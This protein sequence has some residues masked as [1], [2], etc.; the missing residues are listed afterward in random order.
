[1]LLRDGLLDL[2]D[3]VDLEGNPFQNIDLG[4]CICYGVYEYSLLTSKLGFTQ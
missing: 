3:Y 4:N 1:M 2:A